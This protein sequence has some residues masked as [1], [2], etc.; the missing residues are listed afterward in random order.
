MN[1]TRCKS[2]MIRDF[3]LGENSATMLGYRC[4]PCGE[5]FDEVILNNRQ[6]PPKNPTKRRGV[7]GSKPVTPYN[8]NLGLR[9]GLRF[10][11]KFPPA[12]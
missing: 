9:L 6:T 4:L 12:E 3:F 2:L 5:F 8:L 10:V 1:C 11:N 7:S